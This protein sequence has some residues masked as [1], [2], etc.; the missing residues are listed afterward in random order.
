MQILPLGKSQFIDSNGAPLAGGQVFYYAPGT[1]N[2]VN[3]YQDSSGTVP[4]TN[5]VVL[6][7]NGQAVIWGSGSFRQV[8]QNSAGVTI[9]DQ[10]VQS[11]D[12]GF[13]LF[14]SNLADP[15]LVGNGDALVAVKQPYSGAVSRNQHQKN[16][17]RISI[18]DFGAK[19]DGATNDSPA[20]QAAENACA[21]GT[22]LN[23]FI[24]DGT[25]LLNTNV[26]AGPGTI[27]WQFSGGASLSG[28]GTLAHQASSMTYNATPNVSKR[29]SVWHG[30]AANP[31]TDGTTPTAYIQRVDKSVSGDTAANLIPALYV[32]HKRLPGGTGWLYGGYFYLEDQSTS[33]AAQSVGLASSAHGVSTGAVWGLY[34]EA[35]AHNHAVTATGFEVDTYNYS[36]S[37][38]TYNDTFPTTAPFTCGVWNI[39]FGPNKNTFAHGIASGSVANQWRTGIY[40]KTFS[41]DHIGIDIQAQPQTLINFKYGASTDG[42]GIT[43]GGIGLDVGLKAAAS[44]GTGPNQCAIHMR[45]QR[46]GFGSFAFMQ[47]NVATNAIELWVYNGSTYDRR[48]YFDL[49]A[50]DHAF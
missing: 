10:V 18:K 3:T 16:A 2:P 9:W 5:P 42:T 29:M 37:D 26:T 40:M 6:D 21:A 41:V 1:T 25:Y 34:T 23:V 44:Y 17:E 47:F 38:Y 15:S 43:P 35:W 31:T 28:T 32:T 24:P 11:A 49:A 7:S 46:L 36:G 39:S 13:V 12:S 48:G 30:T 8:V 50:A 22:V 19:G 45:D 33:G 14:Q 27:N 4:N 20:F